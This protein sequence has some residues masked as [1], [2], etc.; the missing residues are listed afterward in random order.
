M[1][2]DRQIRFEY[3]TCEREKS[4]IRNKK[5]GFKNVRMCVNEALVAELSLLKLRYHEIV[6]H[7]HKEE[8]SRTEHICYIFTPYWS[9]YPIGQK[10]TGLGKKT[11]E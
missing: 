1:H 10:L 4:Q 3:A 5:S 7:V 8:H 6:T 9:I 2:V 11:L